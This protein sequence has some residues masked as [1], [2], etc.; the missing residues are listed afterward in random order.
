MICRYLRHIDL[1]AVYQ[2][3]DSY[4]FGLGTPSLANIHH[5]VSEA[6]AYL[7]EQRAAAA[8]EFLYDGGVTWHELSPQD[9]AAEVSDLIERDIEELADWCDIPPPVSEG[10]Q[11]AEW[12]EQFQ[13]FTA[14]AVDK[15]PAD[16]FELQALLICL[17]D[18]ACWLYNRKDIEG[19]M[20]VLARIEEAASGFAYVTA[21]N[22]AP[23]RQARLAAN[24]R[25]EPTNDA[26]KQAL[27]EW[28]DS[29]ALYSSKRA[30]ARHNHKKYGVMQVTVERWITRHQKK[31]VL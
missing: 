26:R 9:V 27:K 10:L 1:V 28:E 8:I 5:A 29:G 30:F 7:L 24:K 4:N 15:G 12:F 14:V 6:L 13:V 22:T 25:H 17:H 2:G 20:T 16:Y 23:S 21:Q 3:L 31:G 11:D 19:L 18:C